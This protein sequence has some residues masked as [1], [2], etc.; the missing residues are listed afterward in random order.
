[1]ES[2]MQTAAIAY[3]ANCADKLYQR[4]LQQC[5][6]LSNQLLATSQ[7]LLGHL[8][9][10]KTWGADQ[11]QLNIRAA[12]GSIRNIQISSGSGGGS[13]RGG[14]GDQG[15]YDSGYSGY[16][17]P[18]GLQPSYV[19]CTGSTTDANGMKVCY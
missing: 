16:Q 7:R 10:C 18:I 9:V 3:N 14:G 13:R 8:G 6:T 1:M 12:R 19:E 5:S 11:V 15:G 2:E 4:R 17:R